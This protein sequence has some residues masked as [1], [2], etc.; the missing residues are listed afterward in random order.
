VEAV[1]E[2]L[3]AGVISARSAARGVNLCSIPNLRFDA[4]V[5]GP[6]LLDPGL[7][8]LLER[9]LSVQAAVRVLVLTAGNSDPAGSSTMTPLSLCWALECT[10]CEYSI[11]DAP[12]TELRLQGSLQELLARTCKSVAYGHVAKGDEDDCFPGEAQC[13]SWLRTRVKL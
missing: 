10:G 7:G 4:L 13:P 12:W 11:L 6:S 3:G 2:N 9:V 8:S 5:L 1:L